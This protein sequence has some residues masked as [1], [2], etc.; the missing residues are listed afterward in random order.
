[1]EE[2]KWD[3][4]SHQ[5]FLSYDHGLQL[6]SRPAHEIFK[7]HDCV[8]HINIIRNIAFTSDLISIRTHIAT[9]FIMFLS[10]VDGILTMEIV[11]HHPNQKIKSMY[12]K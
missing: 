1:M 9:I 5:P 8:S 6:H 10:S 4:Q 12:T 11:S 2:R 3:N 7:G